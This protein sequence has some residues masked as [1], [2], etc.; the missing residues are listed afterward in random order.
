MYR[1]TSLWSKRYSAQWA[2]LL[3]KLTTLEESRSGK[4]AQLVLN[5][6]FPNARWLPTQHDTQV[7]P[8]GRTQ[9]HDAESWSD[10]RV[11]LL[12]PFRSLLVVFQYYLEGA[13]WFKALSILHSQKWWPPW[14]ER[15]PHIHTA[16]CK[17]WHIS[18]R[19]V[20]PLFLFWKRCRFR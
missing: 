1:V 2:L 8:H 10:L 4:K 7:L 20:H 3:F 13:L 17:S 5:M 9:L 6:P 11:T 18:A 15:G 19:L 14:V 12:D 16:H